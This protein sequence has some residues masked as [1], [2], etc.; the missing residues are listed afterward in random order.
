[1][2]AAT[3]NPSE[4]LPLLSELHLASIIFVTNRRPSAAVALAARTNAAAHVRVLTTPDQ[5]SRTVQ[6]GASWSDLTAQLNRSRAFVATY[7]QG[8][9]GAP[10]YWRFCHARW[11]ILAGD[12]RDH[13]L[14]QNGAVA[15]VDD[16]VLLF[17]SVSARLREASAF[18]PGSHAET[19]VNGAF[20]MASVAA[21][22]RFAAFLTSLYALPPASLGAPAWRFGDRKRLDELNDVQRARLNPIF[23]RGRSCT[24]FTDMHAIDAFRILSREAR[25]PPGLRVRWSAGHHRH[26][27]ADVPRL[28]WSGQS[29]DALPFLH[30]A[31]YHG[32]LGESVSTWTW[33]DGVPHTGALDGT[34]ICFVHLQGPA[35]KRDHLIP[36][37]RR[38]GLG[39]NV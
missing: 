12:L 19:V 39:L 2:W 20:V 25:L 18:H 14:P 38:A 16:D 21:L 10:D 30:H 34:P 3:S 31:S 26:Q 28:E 32:R 23:I 13:P 5:R 22:E 37:L 35:A 33:R 1:M 24:I 9:L 4:P 8:T 27:C 6:L 11:I 36:M 7:R 17:E 29:R 15:I